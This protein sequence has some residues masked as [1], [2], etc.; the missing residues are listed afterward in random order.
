MGKHEASKSSGKL[1]Q[2]KL[3]DW[4][5]P[6]KR[7]RNEHTEPLEIKLPDFKKPDLSGAQEA[8][9]RLFRRNASVSAGKK[10]LI[11]EYDFSLKNVAAIGVGAL[12]FM[13]VWL[14]PTGGWVRVV[15]FLIP[16]LVLGYEC[17]RDGFEEILNRRILGRSFLVV[18]STIGAFCIG[19]YP[20]AVFVM[21][22]FRVSQMVEAFS[23]EQKEELQQELREMRPTDAHVL[24]EG[25]YTDT[26]AG[27]VVPQDV[28][29]VKNGEVIP[30]DGMV[31]D[32]M[33][34]LDLSLLTGGRKMLDVAPGSSV[35]S[36]MIN[37]G[38]EIQ[39]KV[40]APASS[41]AMQRILTDSFEAAESVPS[42]EQGM[43][44]ALHLLPAVF[45]VLALVIGI[46]VPA[47]A[48]NWKS[49]L[50]RAF[51]LLAVSSTVP[52]LTAL[53]YNIS[54]SI[55][56]GSLSGLFYK[57]AEA[58]DKLAQTSTVVFSK[59]GT[60]TEGRYKVE[61]V[62]SDTYKEKDLLMIAALAECQS[63]HPIA[64]ALRAACGIGVT[65]REDIHIIEE[66][67]S[68][69][70]STLFSGRNVYVGN[71]SLLMEHGI[72][73]SI[74]PRNGT[75][76]HVAVDSEYAG[77]IVLTDRIRDG[78][79][80]AIEELRLRGAGE[81]VMLTGDVRSTSRQIASSLNF[82]LV[83]T[84]LTPDGKISAVEYLKASKGP[85]DVLTY[86]SSS[87]EDLQ[88]LEHADVALGF[89]ALGKEKLAED[90]DV[91]VMGDQMSQIPAAYALSRKAK[92]RTRQSVILYGAVKALLLVFGVTGV[93]SI[94]L[95]AFIDLL[96]ACAVLLNISRN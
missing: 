83:K 86:I 74:P 61:G 1:P 80:D 3:P 40:T 64:Q 73:F 91:T 28:I 51:L 67:P 90:A 88:V 84:E 69:G 53:T 62:Y 37:R 26:D 34:S 16:Y 56:R 59:T 23:R 70:I 5:S 8:V 22:A 42:S 35:Y 2:I 6:K 94:W 43:R 93:F 54:N 66:L 63:Q 95:A 44:Y 13:L 96:A 55:L 38:E 7:A 72:S 50:Y 9:K 46:I 65:T 78:A 31:I 89:A 52:M 82:D 48:G 60:V 29:Q 81:T 21:L 12:L 41:S 75:V 47:F 85:R 79:F 71:A 49:W 39:V 15:T 32:G 19:E 25:V 76:I 4:K 11:H 24:S 77:H 45:S 68:R 33:T 10:D 30:V 36:G 14:I 20:T 92:N 57:N 17:L 27:S 87:E 18:V 58:L